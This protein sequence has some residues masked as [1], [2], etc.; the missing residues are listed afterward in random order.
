[1]P[2]SLLR[3]AAMA[4]AVLAAPALADP[5]TLQTASG[6]LDLARRPDTLVA[7]DV[8]A[9]DTLG[10]LGVVPDGTVA[11]LYVSY[12]DPQ[13]EGARAVGTLFE[14]DFEAI[15]AMAPDLILIGGR[16]VAQAGA[17]ASIAPVADMSIGADALGDGLAR[18]AALGT[19]TGTG[20]RARDLASALLGKADRAKALIADTGDMLIVMTNGPKLSVFGAASRFGWLHDLGWPE[21]APGLSDARHGEAV[22]FEFIAQTNPDTL[23]VIDRGQAVNGGDANA[24]ATLD[25]DLIHG[26]TAW[27]SGRVIYL[28]PAEIYVAAG[29]IQALNHT[30]DELI[31]ALEAAS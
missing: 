17:L 7:L 15:A 29:G 19:L 25:N 12:M 5:I 31:A 1:M 22:T 28:S 13:A 20:E 8:A 18:L 16:S 11:P 21:A 27:A 2:A 23:I 10:A 14:P 26:T 30:L 9:I 6:P 4:A 3:R 24:R